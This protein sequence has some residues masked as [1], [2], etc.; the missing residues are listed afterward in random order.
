MCEAIDEEKDPECLKLSFNLV[1]AVMKLFPDP[2]GL[3]AQYASEVFEILSKYYPIYFTHGVG[4]DLD[5]TRDDLS[6]A[7]MV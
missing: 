1:E 4:D 7:L 2:S 5:A 6:K 3:A